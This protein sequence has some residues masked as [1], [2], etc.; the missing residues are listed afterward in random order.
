MPIEYTQL[1]NK[2]LP[3]ITCQQ[4]GMMNAS[5]DDYRGLVQ[6]GWRKLFGRAYCAITCRYCRAIIGW[7]KP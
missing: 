7:E 6:S 5:D 2:P 1:K 4:C 3:S